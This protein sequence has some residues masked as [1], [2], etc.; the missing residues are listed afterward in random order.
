LEEANRMLQS[1]AYTVSHDLRAP[2]RTI[3]GLSHALIEDCGEMLDNSGRDYTARISDCA[4]RMD[5]LIR[6]LLDY[7]RLSR[8][9]MHVEPLSL[10]AAVAEAIELQ[11]SDTVGFHEP[12]LQ[13]PDIRVVNS[14]GDVMGHAPTVVQ[15]FANLIG[16]AIKFVHPGTHPV[17]TI[18]SETRGSN[19]RVWVEDNGIGVDP[20][21]QT[22]IF[23][24]FERLHG[25]SEFPGTGIGLA[26]V[27]KGAERLGGVA[28]VESS[29]G[30]GSRFW[31]ELKSVSKG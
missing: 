2:L 13:T 27:R 15:I 10:D 25:Q 23:E 18:R 3:R 30:T 20:Q 12:G 4:G 11:K 24:V 6:D 14:L 17:V 31:F 22:R 1:F 21:H 16:N 9:E 8:A 29:Y 19:V 5:A 26:I 28:G 7:S